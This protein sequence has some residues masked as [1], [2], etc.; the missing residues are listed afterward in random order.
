MLS[1]FWR[2]GQYKAY[3]F[4]Y[5]EI[6]RNAR[7]PFDWSW[8][9]PTSFRQCFMGAIADRA[10]LH[11][12]FGRALPLPDH[13]TPTTDPRP[14]PWNFRRKGD[15]KNKRIRKKQQGDHFLVISRLSHAI[16]RAQALF[17]MSLDN[18]KAEKTNKTITLWKC[19]PIRVLW[20][21]QILKRHLLAGNMMCNYWHL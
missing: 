5:V 21:H 13:W 17:D 10:T 9:C 11:V 12:V 18:G 15:R 2:P 8:T 19:L 14:R 7:P 1:P 4:M 6:Y 20:Y 16:I 3:I